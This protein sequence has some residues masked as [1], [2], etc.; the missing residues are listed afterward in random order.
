MTHIAHT[1]RLSAEWSCSVICKKLFDSV[2]R[3]CFNCSID[4]ATGAH[5]MTRYSHVLMIL[6][7]PLLILAPFVAADV[8]FIAWLVGAFASLAAIGFHLAND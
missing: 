1:L 3:N 6:A 8:R 7:L 4:N 2:A 5:D